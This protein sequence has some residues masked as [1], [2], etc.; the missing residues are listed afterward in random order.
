MGVNGING[1]KAITSDK[2]FWQVLTR[3][4]TEITIYPFTASL[5]TSL[6]SSP[7]L[8]LLF[9]YISELVSCPSLFVSD[10]M[11]LTN[12][13]SHVGVSFNQCMRKS[14]KPTWDGVLNLAATLSHTPN[15]LSF[16]A[17]QTR[18]WSLHSTISSK[19]CRKIFTAFFSSRVCGTVSLF[20]TLMSDMN[21]CVCESI[22]KRPA[23]VS[24]M[25]IHT[26]STQSFPSLY[27]CM[28]VSAE[29]GVLWQLWPWWILDSISLRHQAP[30]HL[31]PLHS[32]WLIL[33]SR[34]AWLARPHAVNTALSIGVHHPGVEAENERRANGAKTLH[35]KWKIKMD[36]TLRVAPPSHR[37]T[38]RPWFLP[39]FPRQVHTHTCSNT[40]SQTQK[41]V[42]E[43]TH[44]TH[45]QHTCAQTHT[46][47]SVFCLPPYHRLTV[48]LCCGVSKIPFFLC[49]NYQSRLADCTTSMC[50]ILQS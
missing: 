42:H 35:N 17:F 46:H 44:T 48:S 21:L 47:V 11:H 13:R 19:T 23:S 5:P 37:E 20:P 25:F 18:C 16:I 41:H 24:P 40:H 33:H 36:V 28:C 9:L 1:I 8:S 6:H 38:L 43:P 39:C 32:Q 4:S 50:I 14:Y 3:V 10:R 34:G 30:G 2:C 45:T 22:S 15:S 49:G 29:P 7:P 31:S 12:C 27:V 26:T